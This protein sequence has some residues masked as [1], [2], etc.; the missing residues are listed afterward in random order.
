MNQ[1]ETPGYPLFSPEKAKSTPKPKINLLKLHLSLQV[2]DG[3]GAFENLLG[4]V[5]SVFSLFWV[6]NVEGGDD[7]AGHAHSITLGVV[8]ATSA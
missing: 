8:Y 3:N 7:V 2:P 5:V 6:D 1:N 4:E